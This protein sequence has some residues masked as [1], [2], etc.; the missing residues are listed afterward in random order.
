MENKFLATSRKYNSI[1]AI[2]ISVAIGVVFDFYL[3]LNGKS[4]TPFQYETLF[5]FFLLGQNS[6]I[7]IKNFLV[8]LLVSATKILF[9]EFGLTFSLI[10]ESTIAIALIIITTIL[11]IILSIQEALRNML[12]SVFGLAVLAGCVVG[13]KTIAG[14]KLFSSYLLP[15]MK[16][17]QKPYPSINPLKREISDSIKEHGTILIVWESLGWPKDASAIASFID[18][19]LNIQIKRIDHEGGS[20][21]TAEIRYLCGSNAGAMNY[22]DCVPHQTHSEAFHGNALSY[23]QRQ[24]EY[25]KMG[26]KKFSGRQELQDLKICHYAYNA[27]CDDYL[28]DQVI[29]SARDSQCKGLFYA[30]TIDSHFPY[31]KYKNHVSDLLHD[32]SEALTKL[33][34]VKQDYPDCNIVII[35]D[36]PP[37][38]SNAFDP[39]AV[40]RIDIH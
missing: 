6:K 21:L 14:D 4:W 16:I 17:G 15:Q 9:Y 20:T 10:A 18:K 2:V 13:D 27:V 37:P 36:H 7:F 11:L 32:V 39:K 28:I 24:I 40:M 23:F 29:K 5:S 1:A 31:N 3:F 38:V 22:A 34:R 25:P 30:M 12:L 19:N 26:F 8:L 33:K 35:G